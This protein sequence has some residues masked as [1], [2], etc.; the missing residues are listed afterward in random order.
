[1]E[2]TLVSINDWRDGI[3]ADEK[4]QQAIRAL[5]LSGNRQVGIRTP[6]IVSLPLLNLFCCYREQLSKSRVRED[7]VLGAIAPRDELTAAA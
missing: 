3:L 7:S 6:E 2:Q 1:M 5:Q 4:V